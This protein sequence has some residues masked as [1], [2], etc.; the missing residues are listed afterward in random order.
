MY[1]KLKIFTSNNLWNDDK[2]LQPNEPNE[3][4]DKKRLMEK[5]LPPR[6]IFPKKFL[7]YLIQIFG[8]IYSMYP[9]NI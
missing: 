2:K 6:L 9:Q 1:A 4:I 3:V 7:K 5:L 8:I